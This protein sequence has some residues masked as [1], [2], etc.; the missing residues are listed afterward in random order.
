[1]QKSIAAALLLSSASAFSWFDWFSEKKA[2][3]IAKQCQDFVAIYESPDLQEYYEFEELEVQTYEKCKQ[4]NITEH[5][6]SELE[7]LFAGN[8]THGGC[9]YYVNMRDARK[10]RREERKEARREFRERSKEL[11]ERRKQAKRDRDIA[12]ETLVDFEMR[13][14]EAEEKFEVFLEPSFCAMGSRDR[15]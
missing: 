14:K 7:P 1:M 9:D 4:G 11:R 15:L 12:A 6:F 5:F 2:K 10:E 3:K 13:E 8:S